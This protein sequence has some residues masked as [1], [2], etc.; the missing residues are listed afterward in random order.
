MSTDYAR[1]RPA[2]HPVIRARQLQ[3]VELCEPEAPIVGQRRLAPVISQADIERSDT[4][5]E[6]IARAV[7]ALVGTQLTV[8]QR[9]RHKILA[10]E[11]MRQAL[12]AEALW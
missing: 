6:E 9:R 4:I 7:A 11:L 10:A 12:E 8:G 5:Q 1:H 3:V 2:S